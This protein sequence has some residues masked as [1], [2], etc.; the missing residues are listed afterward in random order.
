MS[1]ATIYQHIVQTRGIL[2]GKPRIDGHRI[3]VEHIVVWHEQMRYNVYE[4]ADIY[5]LTLAEVY[6]ALAYY[7]DHKEKIDRAIEESQ[8]FINELRQKNPSL[9][10]Q[11]LDERL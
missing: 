2:G 5:R 11:K 10:A 3:A 7:H 1:T 4:I 6:T 9:L 8:A